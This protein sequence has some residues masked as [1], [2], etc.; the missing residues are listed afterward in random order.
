MREKQIGR[1]IYP[2]RVA[3]RVDEGRKERT[4]S[5]GGG[6]ICGDFFLKNTNFGII[7]TMGGATLVGKK[8]SQAHKIK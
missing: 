3:I 4:G 6:C 2:A 8:R 7:A 5:G 1:W